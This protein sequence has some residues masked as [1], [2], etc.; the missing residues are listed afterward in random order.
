M[1]YPTC[2]RRSIGA[3]P[4]AI[5][6]P[7]AQGWVWPLRA[8]SCGLTAANRITGGAVFTMTLPADRQAPAPAD[9]VT[10]TAE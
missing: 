4:R 6:R 8:A 2:S 10:A 1:I 9:P 5:G 7:G 3:N